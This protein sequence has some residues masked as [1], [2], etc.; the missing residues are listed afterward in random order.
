VGMHLHEAELLRRHPRTLL[1]RRRPPV[2]E[3]TR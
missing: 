3:F 1:D 2:L